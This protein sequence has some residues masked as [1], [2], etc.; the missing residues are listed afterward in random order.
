[1]DSQAREEN[2]LRMFDNRMMRG[3]SGDDSEKK[4]QET[5]ESC[6]VKCF[7]ICMPYKY[8]YGNKIKTNEISG[9]S[10]TSGGNEKGVQN[11]SQN[12]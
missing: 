4:K 7:I 10:G 5:G 1:M 9:T 11:F 3:I 2:G 8:Y 6:T 12:T